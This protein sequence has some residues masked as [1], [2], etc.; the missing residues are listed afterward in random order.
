MKK[1][2]TKTWENTIGSSLSTKSNL[3][4][5]GAEYIGSAGYWGLHHEQEPALVKESSLARSA[6][7]REKR[8]GGKPLT[9]SGKKKEDKISKRK[10]KPVTEVFYY[11]RQYFDPKDYGYT[12]VCLAKENSAPQVK[13]MGDKLSASNEK[14][15]RMVRSSFGIKE[16]SWYYEIEILPHQGNTRLGWSTEKGDIQAPVGYDKFSY[17]YRDKEGTKFHQ[18]RGAPYGAPYGAGD[19]VGFFIRLPPSAKKDTEKKSEL[20][21]PPQ[22]DILPKKKEEEEPARLDTS[23]IRFFKNGIDQG[24][25]FSNIYEGK[26]YAAG[27]LYGGGHIKFNFGPNF[28]FP[29]KEYEYTPMSELAKLVLATE[30][31]VEENTNGTVSTNGTTDHQNGITKP[32][33][34]ISQPTHSEAI[35]TDIPIVV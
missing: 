15:H 22:V 1:T 4:K 33:N 13:I 21:E 19:I 5:S 8:K 16:G 29:P 34:G 3:F 10:F 12:E 26:Y 2:R 7:K 28:K 20:V 17:S 24:V 32:Q 31:P 25:A 6:P 9:K 18:S 27:S 30:K 23:E 14:G 35:Q 11:P